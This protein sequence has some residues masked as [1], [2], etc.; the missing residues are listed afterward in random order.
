MS[1][2]DCFWLCLLNSGTS[3]VAGFVVFSI[4]GFMAKEQGVSV[5][6]VVESGK[7]R[8]PKKKDRFTSVPLL[9]RVSRLI[10]QV[11]VWPSL[12]IPRRQL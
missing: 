10:S 4:L 11:Q 8:S 9:I 2:R 6:T 1:S 12:R 5:D 3:F 7:L